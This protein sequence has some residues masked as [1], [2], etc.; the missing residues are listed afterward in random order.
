MTTAMAVILLLATLILVVGLARRVWI[1]AVTPSPLRIATMPAPLTR[2]GA[3]L[4]VAGEIG[5]F[6]SLFKADKALWGAAVLFHGGLALV[7]LRHLRYVLEPAPLLLFPLQPLGIAGALAMM[8]GLV[9][10]LA[11]RLLL[12]RVRY[13]T[14]ATD[15][16]WLAL[17]L[18]IGASGLSMTFLVHTDIM[19]VKGFVRGLATLDSKTLPLD[20]PLLV[21]LLAVAALAALLPFSKLLHIPGI[22]F[23]PTRHQ[24]DDAREHRHVAAW[25]RPL[26]AQA[27]EADH[28]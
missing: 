16:A 6:A 23:S 7:L 14:C 10:L 24:V 20:P 11:R 19:A 26:D 13:V 17:L 27:S 21:H 1:Y 12:A 22:L 28:G 18:L 3:A 25:A 2:T 8:A 5:L 15:F 4:R 9:A